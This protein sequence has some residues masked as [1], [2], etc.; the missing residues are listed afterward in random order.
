M[1][2]Y[3]GFIIVCCYN[4]TRLKVDP[5][6]VNHVIHMNNLVSPCINSPTLPSLPKER[7]HDN[8]VDNELSALHDGEKS[9]F[10]SS[11]YINH[12]FKHC[13]SGEGNN[14]KITSS[15]LIKK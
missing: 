11:M 14:T 10:G 13:G 7:M 8:E 1:L 12:V 3:F 9:T 6:N 5:M 15:Y 2:Y 4:K